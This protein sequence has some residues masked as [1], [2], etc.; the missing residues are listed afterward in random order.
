MV[1]RCT[2]SLLYCDI[3]NGISAFS[4]WSVTEK[5]FVILLILTLLLLEVSEAFRCL[6]KVL[7]KV[8]VLGLLK[9]GKEECVIVD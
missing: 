4:G 3:S 2:V 8:F 9:A 7:S 1:Y 6:S 5:V